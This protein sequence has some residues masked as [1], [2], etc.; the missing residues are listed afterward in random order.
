MAAGGTS[1]G[2][3]DGDFTG[4]GR[5]TQDDLDIMESYLQGN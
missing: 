5:V 1:Y 3:Q 4:D 2:W